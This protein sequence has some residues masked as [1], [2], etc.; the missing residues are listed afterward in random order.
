MTYEAQV[1]EETAVS[2]EGLMPTSFISWYD[3]QRSCEGTAVVDENGISYG[4]MRL[5][6]QQEW[7]D[8]EMVCWEM[9]ARCNVGR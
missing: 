4:T 6:T 9:A 2:A 8:L 1:Q 3:A 7:M 5:A